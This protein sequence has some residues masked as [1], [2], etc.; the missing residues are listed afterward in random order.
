MPIRPYD[1]AMRISNDIA[2]IIRDTAAELFGAP[3]RLFGSRLDD[4]ARGGDIDLYVETDLATEEAE[5]RRLRMLAR[6]ARRLGDRKIDLVVK[7][8]DGELP[9]HAIARREGVVL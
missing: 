1:W 5:K 2:A 6:L 4:T 9:I 8:P 3:V 7:T